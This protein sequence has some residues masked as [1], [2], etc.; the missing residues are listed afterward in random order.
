MS[1]RVPLL[2]NVV[3]ML[4]IFSFSSNTFSQVP[5]LWGMT[6]GGGAYNGGTIFKVNGD[7]SGLQIIYSFDSLTGAWPTGNMVFQDGKLYGVTTGGGMWNRGGLFSFD[8]ANLHY[9]ALYD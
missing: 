9:S 6:R 1:I 5:Q 4:V 2:S 7:G 8:P 3:L